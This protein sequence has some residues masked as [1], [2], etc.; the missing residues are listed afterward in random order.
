MQRRCRNSWGGVRRSLDSCSRVLSAQGRGGGVTP[1]RSSS[2]L[3][4]LNL[5]RHAGA[6]SPGSSNNPGP[7]VLRSCRGTGWGSL[8]ERAGALGSLTCGADWTGMEWKE[9]QDPCRCWWQTPWKAEQ[10]LGPEPS[11]TLL[12]LPRRLPSS[13]NPLLS[14]GKLWLL[15]SSF[16]FLP[17]VS[18][19]FNSYN[20]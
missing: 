12:S 3:P 10:N 17:F 5:P 19:F 15:A 9:L 6:L 16:Q 18:N 4:D 14:P 1:Q 13:P 7:R 2:S 11:L 20:S 8:G